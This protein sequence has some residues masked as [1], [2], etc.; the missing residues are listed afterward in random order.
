M[1]TLFLAAVAA[2]ALSVGGCAVASVDE[3]AFSVVDDQKPFEVRRYD[4]M[5]VATV[6][7]T[8]DRNEAANQ[9]FRKLADYIFGN[10]QPAD[11]IAMTAPVVQEPA[12]AKSGEDIAMTAPV[13]QESQPVPGSSTEAGGEP[14]AEDETKIAMTAPVLQ[15]TRDGPA[16]PLGEAWF[17][18]F[19]MP[20]DYTM[21]TL[22]RP[23]NPDVEISQVP[24]RM[25]AV[26]RFSGIARDKVISEKTDELRR[27]MA[28]RD[29]KPAGVP[30]IAYYNPPW[31]LPS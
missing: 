31:T 27:F 15:E 26:I 18:R 16:A 2:A 6:Q 5:I 29:L 28:E 12:A 11:K 10:N 23:V 13:L 25:A 14:G 1:R 22:P 20:A 17:V 4:P 8:G 19:V 30:Q 3:P 7:V 24:S 21:E 9:G